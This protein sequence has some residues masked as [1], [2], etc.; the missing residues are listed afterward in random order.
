MTCVMQAAG[1]V[2]CC[3]SAHVD[4]AV[5][6]LSFWVW[7][8]PSPPS[9]PTVFFFFGLSPESF[10]SRSCSIPAPS[11]HLL[12]FFSLFLAFLSTPTHDMHDAG[13]ERGLKKLWTNALCLSGTRYA[14]LRL[15]L[16][17]H[18]RRWTNLSAERR[19]FSDAMSPC[20]PPSSPSLG[21]SSRYCA[22]KWTDGKETNKKSVKKLR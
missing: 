2:P 17:P 10:P 4:Y 3:E 7:H 9:P 8:P 14:S 6:S 1:R 18:A 22:T 15:A 12:F 13:S 19:H 20:C 21:R 11:H 5:A 16:I